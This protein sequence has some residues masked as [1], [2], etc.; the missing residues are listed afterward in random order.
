MV[1]GID[2]DD[3]QRIAGK[4]DAD[5]VGEWEQQQLRDYMDDE[6]GFLPDSAKDE[7]ARRIGDR[8]PSTFGFSADEIGD[9]DTWVYDPD[10]GTWSKR[11]GN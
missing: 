4:V 5:K 9:S 7:F 6:M 10:G 1:S 2:D 8:P 11:G 3:V